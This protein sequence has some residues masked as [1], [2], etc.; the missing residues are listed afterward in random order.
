MRHQLGRTVRSA[1]LG[2][3]AHRGGL[4]RSRNGV[5]ALEFALLAPVLFVMVAGMFDL[6]R[7][8]IAW[9]R[10]ATSAQAIA[11]ISTSEAATLLG[12]NQLNQS[13]A[14]T[15]ATAIFAFLP[16]TLSAVPSTFGVTISS[17]V[18]Q[19]TVTGCTSGCT[20]APHVAWSGVYEGSGTMRPCDA[21]PGVSAMSFVADNANPSPTTLPTDLQGIA[22]LLVVDVNY[23]FQPLF[24]MFITGNISMNQSAYFSPR[25]G[26][27][28]NW[29]QYYP[30]SPDST[31]LCP[32][33][34]AATNP[35]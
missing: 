5:A 33:Y 1:W 2:F 28:T 10:V 8:Y 20:Y 9:K 35:T 19:P 26:T 32:N 13:Q 22:P 31:S 27:I 34:P 21:R 16:D 24:F 23:T 12:T 15:A 30:G 7:G 3:L 17:V 11:E 29:V 4:L 25:T 18:M 14:T 6:T